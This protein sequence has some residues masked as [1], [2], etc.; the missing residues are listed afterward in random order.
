MQDLF[1]ST[2]LNSSDKAIIIFLALIVIVL[3]LIIMYKIDNIPDE[4]KKNKRIRRKEIDED[5]EE[6]NDDEETAESKVEELFS[7]NGKSF[8]E[9]EFYKLPFDIEND[10][11]ELYKDESLETDKYLPSIK[12]D[13]INIDFPSEFDEFLSS[14]QESENEIIEKDENLLTDKIEEKSETSK[15]KK[16]NNKIEEKKLTTKK[17]TSKPPTTKKTDTT[18]KPAIESVKKTSA[19]TTSKSKKTTAKKNS[20]KK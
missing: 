17:V 18:K 4:Y 14:M 16:N 19:K 2:T 11:E 20:T 8:E 12:E 5:L 3:V 10:K 7:Q 15:N 1:K 9:D 13:E 6:Q